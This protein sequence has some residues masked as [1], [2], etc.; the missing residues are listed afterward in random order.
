MKLNRTLYRIL[1]IVSFLML[2]AFVIMGIS[3]VISYLNTGADRSSILHLGEELSPSYLP[4]VVWSPL[5]N[6][7]RP[8]EKQ[9]LANIERD[10]LK[11]WYVKNLALEE[12]KVYGIADYY[13]DSAR[14]KLHA[15]VSLNKKNH[16][17]F[18]TTT[19]S[20]QPTL[21]FYSAD[22]KLVVLTDKHVQY[23]EEVYQD[24]ELIAKKRGTA[25]YQIIL[26][27]EDGF[28]R[29]RHSTKL[30]SEEPKKKKSRKIDL[31]Q[32]TKGRGINY[33]P[34]K[35]PWAMFGEQFNAS[36]VNSDFEKIKVL[37]LNSVRVFIPYEAFGKAE[38]DSAKINQLRTVLDLAHQN[39]LKVLATLFDFYGDY[40][41]SNW[42]LTHRHAEQLVT[43]L[44]DH[45]A[46]LAWDIKNEPDLDFESRGK[47]NV[48]S[49]LEQML[50]QIKS[51]DNQNP[52]TIG[53]ST[54][55]VAEMLAD[56]VDFVSFHYYQKPAAFETAYSQLRLKVPHKPIVLQE[57]GIS[58]YDG[59]YNAYLGAE[60]DQANYYKAM[61]K[62]LE[63]EA[64]PYFLWTLYDFEN[65]P[66]GVVG[67]LPWRKAYQKHFGLIDSENNT[68]EAYHVIAKK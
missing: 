53:W 24:N 61:H 28:W 54:P 58:S 8:M 39:D 1:L 56:K 12:N 35:T 5:E 66:N 59:M 55:E 3:A 10:Y 65:I 40:S 42:T 26:L 30:T 36:T 68:K 51:W 41:P 31:S 52:V 14:V 19:F 21:N 57:Y 27:L 22:G 63:K 37:G 4:K 49:W 33:Y 38:V 46:L 7:G 44:K 48:I 2:N 45:P 60:E 15:L 43:Q 29:I 62:V 17:H 32:I 67:K 11:A 16:T 18:K 20:H 47:D 23:Y 13:T 9:T 50:L 34:Q 64:I 25:T 6:E